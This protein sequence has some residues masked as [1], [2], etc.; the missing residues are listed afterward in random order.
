MC[1]KVSHS[2]AT[3]REGG[4]GRFPSYAEHIITLTFGNQA[5]A[6]V[7]ASMYVPA[8]QSWTSTTLGATQ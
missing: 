6:Y 8:Q 2:A 3:S 5:A 4:E 1:W 7:D